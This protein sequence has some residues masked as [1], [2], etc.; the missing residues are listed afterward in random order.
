MI[1]IDPRLDGR[2]RSFY[3]DIEAERPGREFERFKVPLQR[4]QRR[5]LNFVA[6]IAGFAI[7][8]AGVGVLQP[9]WR[10]VTTSSLPPRHHAPRSRPTH[11]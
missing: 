9:S 6:G 5:P 8:A 1:D 11:N 10:A 3:E 2:L 7:A 4:P